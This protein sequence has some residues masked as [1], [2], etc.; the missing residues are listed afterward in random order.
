MRQDATFWNHTKWKYP[1][2]ERHVIFR[3]TMYWVSLSLP[4][5][6][7]LYFLAKHNATDHV[8]IF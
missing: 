1:E 5:I 8:I 7:I 2:S 6:D 3:L 4:F